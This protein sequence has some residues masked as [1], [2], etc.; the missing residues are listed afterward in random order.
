M[1]KQ[2]LF[3]V[4]VTVDDEQKMDEAAIA[5]NLMHWLDASPVQID[6]IHP[7]DKMKI[8]N[9]IAKTSDEHLSLLD[10]PMAVI[11][12]EVIRERILALREIGYTG[13]YS[14][15]L[16]EICQRNGITL[17]KEQRIELLL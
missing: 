6:A 9:P 5:R 2:Y 11:T 3:A 16:D 8:Y 15:L 10:I 14:A 17:S 12:P 4:Q 1:K 13:D 7:L